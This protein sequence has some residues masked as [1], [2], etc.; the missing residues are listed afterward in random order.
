MPRAV[1]EIKG[2]DLAGENGATKRALVDAQFGG[3]LAF[4]EPHG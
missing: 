2:G 3:C 1:A 4:G